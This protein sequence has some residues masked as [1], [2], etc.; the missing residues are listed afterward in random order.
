MILRLG[1]DGDE[2][3]VVEREEKRGILLAITCVRVSPDERYLAYVV[4]TKKQE[5]LAGPREELLI[6]ELTG[7]HEKRIARYGYMGN[8]IWSPD[9]QRLYFAGGEYSSDSAVRVVDVPAV[10]E[11]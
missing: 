7:G 1:P 10:F 5:F 8:L 11:R 2:E 6:R 4:N 3:L 9:S